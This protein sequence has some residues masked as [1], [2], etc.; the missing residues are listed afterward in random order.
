MQKG[1]VLRP[2]MNFQGK[3]KKKGHFNF[4]IQ[5]AL[6]HWGTKDLETAWMTKKKTQKKT[7]KKTKNVQLMGGQYKQN[8]GRPK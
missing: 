8:G 4:T 3:K 1:G 6:D 7:Q 5:F 2:S